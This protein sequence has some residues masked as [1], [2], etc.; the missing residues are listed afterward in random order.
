MLGLTYQLWNRNE[1]ARRVF[2]NGLALVERNVTV[3]KDRAGSYALKALF[4]ARTGKARESVRATIEAFRRD[5]TN[6]EIAFKIARVYAALGDREN[7]LTWFKRAKA[8]NPAEYDVA[9][10]ATALDFE[11]YRKDQELLS[12]AAQEK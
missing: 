10:V 5:S 4:L 11:K 2:G 8:V 6:Y 1:D 3:Q 12:I 7:M 9:F